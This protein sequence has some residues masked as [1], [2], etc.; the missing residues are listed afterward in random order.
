MKGFVLDRGRNG[1]EVRRPQT[2]RDLGSVRKP[3]RYGDDELVAL[4]SRI[5]REKK[6]EK[7]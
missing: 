6:E 5:R 4:V 7:V 1:S 2:P 3:E